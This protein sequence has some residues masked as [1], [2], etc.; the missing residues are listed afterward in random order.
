MQ[1]SKRNNPNR[2]VAAAL[3]A[4][5]VMF[6]WCGCG[7]DVRLAGQKL[8]DVNVRTVT[9]YGLTLDEQ[10]EPEQ[11]AF[12]L[13]R[14]MRDDALA[15]S[16]E[17]REAALDRQFD[18]AA[19]GAITS[20]TPAGFTA[21]ETLHRVVSHWTP[22]VGHYAANFDFDWEAAK[23]RLVRL[24]IAQT[25]GETQE[26]QVLMELD[27][28]DGDPNARAVLIIGLIQEKGFWRVYR[29][30]FVPNQRAIRLRAGVN[31]EVPSAP[32]TPPSVE[33]HE[34]HDHP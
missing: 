32:T 13:L 9:H 27:S 22:V 16:P 31:V 30:G 6:F 1:R 28:P 21:A 3:L 23:D 11:V 4:P 19:G 25:K 34:G 18:V 20:L 12:V 15:Q 29:V 14:A 10:A 8:R 24:S 26:C 33:S 7:R 2:I 17:D 5:V